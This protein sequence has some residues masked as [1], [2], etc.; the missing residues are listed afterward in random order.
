MKL[1]PQD[2][3]LGITLYDSLRNK[4]IKLELKHFKELSISEEA[5]FFRYVPIVLT[6]EILL[7]QGY[8]QDEGF[9]RKTFRD[10]DVEFWE[11]HEWD[12]EDDYPYLV[13]IQNESMYDDDNTFEI[14]PIFVYNVGSL[15]QLENLYQSLGTVIS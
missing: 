8:V 5:F 6:D 14:D 1:Q 13:Y 3:R 9:I 15:H 4:E 7:N 2:L 12:T 10:Y 11:N